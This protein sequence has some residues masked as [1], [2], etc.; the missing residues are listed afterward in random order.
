MDHRILNHLATN[1]PTSDVRLLRLIR[2]AGKVDDQGVSEP[3]YELYLHF[4]YQKLNRE[5]LR[6]A[7]KKQGLR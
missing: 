1:N 3:Q 6:N 4:I 5:Q 7:I 2:Q